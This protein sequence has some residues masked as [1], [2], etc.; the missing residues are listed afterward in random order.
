MANNPDANGPPS[1]LL[2]LVALLAAPIFLFLQPS[3]A[4]ALSTLEIKQ[5]MI[6][7]S[8]STYPGNCPCPD[9]RDSAGRRCGKRSAYSRPGGRAPLCYPDDISD[10]EAGEWARKRGLN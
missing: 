8:A 6:E 1:V 7:E 5:Q 3:P 4:A 10:D 2:M 9:S